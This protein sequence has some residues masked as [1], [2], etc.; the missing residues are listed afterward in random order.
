M[1]EE[2]RIYITHLKV[3]DV[4][5]HRL[6]TAYG[7]GTD[8]PA[9]LAA[10]EQMCDLETVKKSLYEL[11]TNMEHQSTLWHATPFGMVFLSRI[12][13]KAPCGERAEPHSPFP[14]RG[15]AGLL[16]L[17]PPVLPRRG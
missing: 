3:T 9:H 8:F 16:C 7:R 4:P 13:E 15:A 6:T 5:W 12:L 17:H 11:T 10:L 2:N 1:T 14:G